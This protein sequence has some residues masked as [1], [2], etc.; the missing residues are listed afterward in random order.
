M[1][2]LF[3]LFSCSLFF[4]ALFFAV[5]QVKRWSRYWPLAYVAVAILLVLPLDHWLLI[6]FVRGYTSDLSMA[7]VV[8]CAVYLWGVVRP[9]S[10]GGQ[11][12]LKWFVVLVSLVMLPMS[13]GLTQFDPFTMGYASNRFYVYF[14]LALALISLLAWFKGQSQLALVIALAILANGFN[15]YE[16]QNLWVYLMDPIAFIMCGISLITQG[17]VVLKNRIKLKGAVNV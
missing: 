8:I 1:T 7:T 5:F 16:S 9:Q 17:L 3:A 11:L 15:V 2:T 10:K 4:M 12:S 13:L 6:E 14:L